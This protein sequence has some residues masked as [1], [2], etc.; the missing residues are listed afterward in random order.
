MDCLCGREFMVQMRGGQR[1]WALLLFV[2][3]S[4]ETGRGR[5]GGEKGWESDEGEEGVL[6]GGTAGAVQGW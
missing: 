5:K 6:A 3:R 2:R 4:R 1:S